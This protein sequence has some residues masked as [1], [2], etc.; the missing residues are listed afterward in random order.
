MAETMSEEE[1]HEFVSTGT[2][3]GKAAVVKEDGTPHVTPIW[4]LLDGNDLVFTTAAS[5][6]KGKALRR[7]PRI[8]FCVDDETPPYS[9]VSL[10]GEASLSDDPDGLLRWATAL[11]R[12]YMGADRAEAYGARNAVPGELLV[13]VRITKV[14]AQRDI[15]D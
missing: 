1:W 7:D 9:F 11:G 4:F 10:W 8:S 6:I 15:A 2:R 12:R 5:G 14:I 13:R 3:T